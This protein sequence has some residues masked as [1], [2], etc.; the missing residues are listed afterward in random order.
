MFAG[1][2]VSAQVI[3]DN[4]TYIHIYIYECTVL[5]GNVMECY[6]TLCHFMLHDIPCIVMY[7]WMYQFYI[8]QCLYAVCM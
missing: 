2:E 7:V 6:V 8:L 3:Y 5:H 4:I 1:L